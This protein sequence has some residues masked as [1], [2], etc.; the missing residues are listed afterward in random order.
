M[1]IRF[2]N[3][4]HS[5]DVFH[6]KG[7]IQDMQAQ[8]G[9]QVQITYAHVNHPKLMADISPHEE[10]PVTCQDR[11]KASMETDVVNVNTWI[12]AYGWE[13]MPRGEDHANWPSI[14]RMF[15]LIYSQL[16]SMGLPLSFNFDRPELYI[17]TTDFACYEIARGNDFLDRTMDRKRALFCNGRVRSQQSKLELQEETIE[18]LAREFEDWAFIATARFPTDLPNIYFTDDIFDIDNDINEIAYLSTH[19]NIIVGKNSG[20]FMYTHIQDNFWS[21]ETT[22]LSLSHRPSDCYPYHMAWS[23]E[24]CRYLHHC[25]DSNSRITEILREVIKNPGQ[26]RGSVE[27]ID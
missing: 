3:H 22:F 9:D 23:T 12:G 24:A 8:C 15:G 20:P 10:V 27:V 6:A 14:H 7:Y 25:G 17:P 5:G 18:A 2:Y 13:V 19:S 1:K 21:P 11:E 16:R 26:S 4:W